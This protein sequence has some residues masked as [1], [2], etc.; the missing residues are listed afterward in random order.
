PVWFVER[1][2]LQEDAVDET[3][4]RSRRAHANA[5]GQYGDRCKSRAAGQR[6]HGEAPILTK[7]IEPRTD[8]HITDVLLDLFDTTDFQPGCPASVVT[9][10]ALCNLLLNQQVH[11]AVDFVAEGPFDL[12][13]VE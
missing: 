1:K 8:A 12:V 13:A 6:S 5:E 4:N 11:I 9:R 2:R 3:K 10:H 7:H